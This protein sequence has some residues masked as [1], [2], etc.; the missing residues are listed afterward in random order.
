MI[1][2]CTNARP[3]LAASDIYVQ[4][5]RSEGL[6][7]ALAE[8][9]ACA[10]P[11]VVTSVGGNPEVISDGLNGFVVPPGDPGKMAI[12]IEKLVINETL[13]NK[14]GNN[15]FQFAEKNLHPSVILNAYSD[16]YDE[17]RP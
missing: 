2:D 13:R 4:P 5:S 16:L 14:M 17:L 12:A 1:E 9:I 10:L 8:A 7:V 11:A 6:S 3:I 15:S